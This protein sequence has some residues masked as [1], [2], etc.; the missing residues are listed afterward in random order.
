MS[1]KLNPGAVPFVPFSEQ[2][3]LSH[4]THH[5]D[6]THAAHTDH[7]HI[8][9]PVVYQAH[10]NC[11]SP[12]TKGP[13]SPSTN[14]NHV[15]SDYFYSPLANASDVSWNTWHSLNSDRQSYKSSRSTS[16]PHRT[17]H[18]MRHVA[19]H[20]ASISTIHSPTPI[21][22]TV[23][24]LFNPHYCVTRTRPSSLGVRKSSESSLD[25]NPNISHRFRTIPTPRIVSWN[26]DSY[27]SRGDGRFTLERRGRF[28]QNIEA[29][30]AN[31]DVV[32]TQETKTESSSVTYRHLLRPKWKS[33][34]NPNPDNN[35]KGGTD[36]FVSHSF[37]TTFVVEHLIL[38][39][40]YLH[41]IHFN[42][43]DEDS[44]FV[45]GFTIINAY[46]PSGSDKVTRA[47]RLS[48]LNQ[49]AALQTPTE[50]VFAGGDWNLTMHES[51]SSGGD[52]FASSTEQRHA[53]KQTLDTLRLEEVFQPLHTCVRGGK[54]PSSSRI[55]RFY[56][57]HSLADKCIM[58]PQVDLPPHPYPPGGGERS[59]GPSDHFP[60]R[61]S[62][63]PPG[64]AKGAR[65]K[66]PEWIASHPAYL[67]RVRRKWNIVLKP[68]KAGKAWLLFKRVVDCEAK[69]MMREHKES[70][71]SKAGALTVAI[72]L[73]KG[74][75]EGSLTRVECEELARKDETLYQAFK[76]DTRFRNAQSSIPIPDNIINNNIPS[77][78]PDTPK[79]SNSLL[80]PSTA[81]PPSEAR[82]EHLGKYVQDVFRAGPIAKTKRKSNFLK[83]AAHTLPHGKRHLSHLIT[84]SGDRIEATDKIASALKKAWEPVWGH[85]NP[86]PEAISGYLDSYPK[87]A[88]DPFPKVSVEH[89]RAVMSKP[90]D[91]STGPDGIPFSVYRH[92]VD[93]A[94]P[95]LYRYAL[96]LSVGGRINKSFNFTNLFF[97]PKD[98]TGSADRTRPI[99]V[100]NT[101]NRTVANVLRRVMSPNIL[102]IL[103]KSQTA[104]APGK[105]IEEPIYRFTSKF[106]SAL[107]GGSSYSILFHD[108]RKA[109]DSMSRDYLFTLLRKIGTPRWL[110]RIIRSLYLN[111]V[112]LPILRDSH[113]VTIDMPNGLKQGCP[114]S[115]ILF[116]LGLDPLLSKIA[117]NDIDVEAYCDDLGVGTSK[118]EKFPLV[119]QDIT[120]FNLASGMRSNP[121]KCF[122]ITTDESPPDL[123]TIL[124]DTWS[125]VRLTDRYKYLGVLMGPG[126]NINDVFHE[127]WLKLEH[128]VASYMPLKSFYNT[129]NRVI[130]SNAFLSSIF[131]Y[132]FRFY[133]M[134]E[135]YHKDVER[136]LTTWLV[137]ARRFRYD[138]LTAKT[139]EAGLTQPLQD[140]FRLNIAA[141]LRMRPSLPKPSEGDA[142]PEYHW[143]NGASLL[144]DEHIQRAVYYF[145]ALTDLHPSPD[146]E[147]K[148]LYKSL[149]ERDP[150]PLDSLAQKW[151]NPGRSRYLGPTQSLVRAKLVV[152]KTKELPAKLPSKI[153]YHV[154]ELVHNAVPTKVRE[155]WRDH[156]LN[157]PLCDLEPESIEHLHRCP[158][159]I[160]ATSTI[161]S[162][163]PNKN[164]F[165]HILDSTEEDYQFVSDMSPE[166]RMIIIIFSLAIWRTRRHYYKLEFQNSHTGQ[167]ASQIARYFIR[168]YQ[169]IL[170]KKKRNT[171][172][173]VEERN[174]F[175]TLYKSIPRN[176]VC[177]FTDG[178]SLGNPGPSGA[179]YFMS[180]NNIHDIM[181]SR[182]LSHHIPMSTNNA[183]ELTAL[184]LAVDHSLRACI[185]LRRVG[186]TIPVIH[187]FVDN[188]YAIN[189][190]NRKHRVRAHKRI[191]HTLLQ[192]LDTLSTQTD[193]HI[194]WVPGHAGVFGNEVADY[195][196]KR[197][198]KGI[199]SSDP[200]PYS[201]VRRILD[202]WDKTN[203]E[204]LDSKMIDVDYELEIADDLESA[205]EDS[206]EDKDD[207]DED[208][209]EFEMNAHTY[210][211]QEQNSNIRQATYPDNN[212]KS[213]PATNIN[214]ISD[215]TPPPLPPS[216]MPGDCSSDAGTVRETPDHKSHATP[217][218]LRRSSRKRKLQ[219]LV[220]GI[221]FTMHRPH[222]IRKP[223]E[224]SVANSRKPAS[225]IRLA[226]DVGPTN[227]RTT[228]LATR[229]KPK[230]LRQT[231]MGRFLQT[232]T[233]PSPT[234]DQMSMEVL[235]S[236]W[237]D[238]HGG[239]ATRDRV[240]T[241]SLGPV[242]PP[243]GEPPPFGSLVPLI[244][245]FHPGRDPGEPWRGNH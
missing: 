149:L 4:T 133:M 174:T 231:H 140:I 144:V 110:I 80:N 109:Y 218:P 76:K 59:K 241:A 143:G 148:T 68:K 107:N 31:A 198:A 105:H 176:H 115:P 138:Q 25:N 238:I 23:N 39:P 20:T 203:L 14:V 64:L 147:Q 35:L 150:T 210:Q 87:R 94:A 30:A 53:L 74:I 156:T 50:F 43:R 221:D 182:C 187:F 141:L 162:H 130:I 28:T 132:L 201:V 70:A 93:I 219:K 27:S 124:P 85:P 206:D 215:K 96:S 168:T 95:L 63:K 228:S 10:N 88:P 73:Y 22:S 135:D 207:D 13:D 8:T 208:T 102:S 112:A 32:M 142:G 15:H 234:Q 223:C 227:K 126:V 225:R 178:S 71:T 163:F 45:V 116:N 51:D 40:G 114:L 151:D 170:Q 239:M 131:S 119:L 237:D 204:K 84:D 230:R 48:V 106:Y 213:N 224:P 111:V 216:T 173:K 137:P 18:E 123:R 171:R 29:L 159:A 34:K 165:L 152:S 220:Q 185:E 191:V 122:I 61:L 245:S 200:V 58:S 166:K 242:G 172:N 222:K 108:F 158:T 37:L 101:D 38:V 125:S 52:H 3:Q 236:H 157:C 196:A 134:G 195:L 69:N 36:I 118:W 103:D 12:L 17:G 11:H 60:I 47:K 212:N 244:E 180:S 243:S 167:A 145:H 16:R 154:F 62:F 193:Y 72:A 92:L 99:S 120:A 56:I 190:A 209:R 75:R 7:S 233:P 117:D 97:F 194:H 98:E 46:L 155:A 79:I 82:L 77:T 235:L 199:S 49:M 226:A 67:R 5:A 175:I 2:S 91:S 202:K 188:Q 205:E 139:R 100:S 121:N 26:A 183:S 164:D 232:V 181:D 113:K 65:Y 81:S 41:A 33:F 129:Q 54:A 192:R 240:G 83:S 146:L 179:A 169:S 21:A 57:S 127:A 217:Q 6:H 186:D 229:P 19:H 153:R 44:L 136:L 211:N 24:H 214:S 128:R 66:I 42:P 197:G 184:S 78:I 89:F 55:D 9:T 161:F 86:S 189:T 160:K 177:I 90:R 1:R 104:F